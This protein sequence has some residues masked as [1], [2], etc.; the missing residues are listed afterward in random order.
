MN[1]ELNSDMRVISSPLEIVQYTNYELTVD[2]PFDDT[3]TMS[4]NVIRPDGYK[5]KEMFLSYV[6]GI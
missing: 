6:D 4:M 3:Y 5:T 2:A 1:F